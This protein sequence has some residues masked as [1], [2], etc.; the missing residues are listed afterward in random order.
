MSKFYTSTIELNDSNEFDFFVDN[1]LTI[2]SKITWV[3]NKVNKIDFVC[4][5]NNSKIKFEILNITPCPTPPNKPKFYMVLI[6]A[7]SNAIDK[8]R[9]TA[10]VSN[11]I[12]SL[13]LSEE[14][15]MALF[16]FNISPIKID[17]TNPD[18]MPCKFF[19]PDPKTK[20]G[21]IIVGI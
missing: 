6:Y 9:Y 3:S 13:N 4:H 14:N 11:E 21:A 7:N 10:N 12:K 16:R 8:S 17:P 20:N 2:K 1:D 18:F 19:E 5:T 15:D